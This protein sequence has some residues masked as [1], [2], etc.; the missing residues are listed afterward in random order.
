MTVTTIANCLIAVQDEDPGP[1]MPA[2]NFYRSLKKH[3]T[4]ANAMDSIVS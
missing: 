4:I 1:S 2:V 3:A